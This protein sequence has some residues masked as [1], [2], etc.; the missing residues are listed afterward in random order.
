MDDLDLQIIKKLQENAKLSLKKIAK[1]LKTPV[2]TVHFRV[3][4]M[5]N[6]KIIVKFSSVIDIGKLGYET[7]GWAN[8]TVDPLKVDEVANKIASFEEVRMVSMTGGT[9]NLVVQILAKNEKELWNFIRENI[10]TLDGVQKIDVNS[11]LKIFKWDTCYF[12]N[13]PD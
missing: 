8:L 9:Y 12:C 13:I 10:Q 3:Q 4:K 6:E 7:V 2:S 1:M 11:S 5:I